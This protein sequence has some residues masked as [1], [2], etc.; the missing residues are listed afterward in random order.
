[1]ANIKLKEL[2]F[3]IED[4]TAKSKETGKLVYL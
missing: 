4:F 3:E 2:L 1:M